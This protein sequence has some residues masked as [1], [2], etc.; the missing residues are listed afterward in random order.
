MNALPHI[1]VGG[2]LSHQSG[3]LPGGQTAHQVHLEKAFLGVHEAGCK[4]RI[5]AI[6]GAYGH[7]TRLIAADPHGRRQPCQ[8]ARS[9]E[10]REARTHGKPK[11]HDGD[12][13]E[14]SG[15]V[16]ETLQESHGA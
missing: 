11:R 12:Y 5:T 2:G 8:R 16:D 15:D 14:T 1:M 3:Q 9:I 7:Y 10:L 6:P 13:H 4:G